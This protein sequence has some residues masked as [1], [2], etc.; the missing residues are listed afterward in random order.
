MVRET[1]A[2][3][4]SFLIMNHIPAKIVNKIFSGFKSRCM[5]PCECIYSIADKSSCMT[6]A[7]FASLNAPYS[8]IA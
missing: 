2:Q 1:Q 7:V 3:K 6:D 4:Q 8:E 5:T